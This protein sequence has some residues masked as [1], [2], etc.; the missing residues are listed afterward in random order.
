MS[1]WNY[2]LNFVTIASVLTVSPGFAASGARKETIEDLSRDAYI[3]G[4]PAIMM[5]QARENMLGKT[6]SPVS[7]VNHFFPSPKSPDLV[8]KD[9]I[10]ANTENKYAWAWVDLS[11]GP[12]VLN[13]PEIKDRY[14]SVSLV[15][16]FSNVFQV[17]SN[18]TFGEKS[19]VF[20]L[21]AP[22]WTGA[23][24][25]GSTQ[26]KA[27][28]PELFVM[29][30]VFVKERKEEPQITRL[31]KQYQLV[32]LRD[33]NAGVRADSFKDTYPAAGLRLQRNLA[34]QGVKFYE[35]LQQVLAK[36][37][38]PTKSDREE[39]ERFV[40]LGLSDKSN[41]GQLLNDPD[42]RGM[43]ERGIFEGE[44]EIE[45]RLATG[46]GAKVNGWSYEMKSTAFAKD[47]L[48]RAA[49]AKKTLFSVP[50]TEMMQMTVDVD[51]EA[52]QLNSSYR[53]VLHFDEG[54][55]P[56]AR[57]A[58][59]LRVYESLGKNL[60]ENRRGKTSLNDRNPRLKYNSD[61]SIDVLV[62]QDAPDKSE[63]GNWLELSKNSNFYVV[64]TVYNPG[65]LI[66]NRKY[67]AP[68]LTRVEDGLPKQ[69][70][71]RTMMAQSFSQFSRPVSK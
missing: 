45:S 40:K 28:T 59:S 4:Y 24:P 36:N 26:I 18:S 60:V 37:S 50:S 21:T 3:W 23:L 69:K 19:G 62:Q 48:L 44:R 65:N 56:S 51:N 7:S 64:M 17:I 29:V 57:S 38:V 66:L 67:I 22:D 35:E 34:S 52:R 9:F 33:W 27:T 16:A 14:Y 11:K 41:F 15:D 42:A 46:F 10:P 31:M 6:K 2:F 12:L 8:L 30:Q 70:V 49:V 53:Y 39:L 20:V 58:W 63:E 54:D 1:A 68:S 55:F 25:E 13:Q 71:V 5:K 47:F 61:G 32:S 43:V